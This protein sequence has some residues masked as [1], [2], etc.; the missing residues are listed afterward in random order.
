MPEVDVAPLTF[1]DVK[2]VLSKRIETLK[3]KGLKPIS[4]HTEK[5]LKIL[6]DLHNGN[7]REI[8]N[9]LSNCVL[10]LPLSNMPI[11][12]DEFLLRELLFEKVKKDFLSKLTD[13]E[14][15][16]YLVF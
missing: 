16:I 15:K 1:D 10:E 4:P 12:I 2:K 6:F 11:Q 8:L 3:D 13:V 5:A 14:K 7:L 9:S